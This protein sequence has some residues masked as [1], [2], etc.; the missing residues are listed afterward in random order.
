MDDLEAAENQLDFLKH[1]NYKKAFSH[2]LDEYIRLM[3][4]NLRYL[5]TD[6]TYRKYEKIIRNKLRQTLK[7]YSKD[8]GISFKTGFNTYKY[9]YPIRAKVY[10]RIK[11][12]FKKA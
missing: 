9:A 12:L 4:H 3:L 11:M 10:N 1:N 2:I 7:L 8:L 6:K 5:K